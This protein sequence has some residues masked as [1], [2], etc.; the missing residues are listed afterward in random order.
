M[1]RGG[2]AH[3]Q[4]QAPGLRTTGHRPDRGP[5]PGLAAS[6]AVAVAAP[7]VLRGG[8]PGDARAIFV[9]FAG[10]AVLAAL[11]TA[12]R[13]ALALLRRP[14]VLALGALALLAAASAAWTVAEPAGAIR[15][16]LVLAA[17]AAVAVAAGTIARRPGGIALL[18]ALI[19][20]VAALSA[21]V[22]VT[23]VALR[24]EP[25]A[26]RIYG[27]WQP[28]GPFEYP[29]A[30]AMLQVAAFPILLRT[31]VAGAPATAAAGAAGGSLAAVTLALTTSRVAFASALVLAAVAL[32]APAAVGRL[33][34]PHRGGARGAR[35]AVCAPRSCCAARSSRA[36]PCSRR[37]PSRSRGR[38]RRG[39]RWARAGRPGAPASR[40]PSAGAIA[41][42]LAGLLA[43]G[44][45][46]AG[47]GPT[48]GG[49]T[50]GRTAIWE[51]AL[52]TWRERPLAGAGAEAFLAASTPHQSGAAVR[53]AHMLPLE[54][55]VELGIAGL[56]LGVL[57][58]ATAL[59]AV[60]A[61]RGHPA[62]WLFG[63][64]VVTFLAF[65]LVDWTWHLAG[66]GAV[67]AVALGACLA[68]PGTVW[69][70]READRRRDP[71]RA[72]G[73][74]VDARGRLDRARASSWRTSPRR[75]RSP[76]RWP[77]W[78]RPPTTTRTS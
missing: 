72:G 14:P 27:R 51:E 7:V 38:P 59:R 29:P 69:H 34:R 66:A 67:W 18:A 42:G 78:P 28:G 48:A 1:H 6:L 32:A 56:L 31:M 23:A 24:A 22:G 71:A 75:W 76:T 4:A 41:A 39:G 15:W 25:W 2:E 58:Y 10:A 40:G 70:G 9:L 45:L 68:A 49:I 64:A 37:S 35:R 53:Y 57:L 36:P 11:L 77:R 5:H 19:A 63:P 62:A 44:A 55:A 74:A 60:W 21:L 17:Y 13:D 3:R 47:V 12:E 8:Y 33:A 52:T 16:A 20:G 73:L 30:L 50:H 54:L 43:A 46:G 65:N 61:A 26:E